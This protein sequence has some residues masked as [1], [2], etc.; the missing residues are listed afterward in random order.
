MDDMM[1]S[2]IRKY[3]VIIDILVSRQLSKWKV[4][5]GSLFNFE[6]IKLKF[7]IM[8][9]FKLLISNLY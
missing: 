5:I 2:L 7:D 6:W 8:G 4:F 9:N 3:D 1:S